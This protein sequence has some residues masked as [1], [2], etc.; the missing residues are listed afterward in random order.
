MRWARGVVV[1]TTIHRVESRSAICRH[2]IGAVD[3]RRPVT[4]VAG[5]SGAIDGCVR[6]VVEDSERIEGKTLQTRTWCFGCRWW[7][8][9]LAKEHQHR[10]LTKKRNDENGED[11]VEEEQP[12]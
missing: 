10:V 1:I 4:V 5:L 2:T 9:N 8:V 7:E 6:D 12:R 11:G 3:V